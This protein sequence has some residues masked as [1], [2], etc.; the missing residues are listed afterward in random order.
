MQMADKL[1][2]YIIAHNKIV[3]EYV[4]KKPFIEEEQCIH[5]TKEMCWN[6]IAAII[7]LGM[8]KSAILGPALE[9]VQRMMHNFIYTRCFVEGKTFDYD[10][11]QKEIMNAI[12]SAY[13]AEQTAEQNAAYIL[14]D[15]VQKAI[16]VDGNAAADYLHLSE[17]ANKS[18]TILNSMTLFMTADKAVI[19]ARETLTC[20]LASAHR[21]TIAKAI[22][23]VICVEN[24]ADELFKRVVNEASNLLYIQLYLACFH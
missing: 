18:T 12:V 10:I 2:E 20:A 7:K 13:V 4:A 6:M 14:T 22:T 11:S 24:M 3:E 19:A 23:T 8:V 15:A 16:D 5:D 17:P 1:T 21:P 9:A